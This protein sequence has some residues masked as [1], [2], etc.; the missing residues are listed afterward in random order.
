MFIVIWFT[1]A[2]DLYKKSE[3]LWEGKL[4]LLS[5]TPLLFIFQIQRTGIF[6]LIA[7]IMI[8][9]MGITM[10]KLDHAKTKWRIKLQH[11]FEGQRKI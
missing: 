7:T 6:E 8:F 5:P 1:K 9:V 11:A 2:S 3:D 4:S 10:L